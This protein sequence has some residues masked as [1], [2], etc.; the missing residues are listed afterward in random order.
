MIV[1]V[2]GGISGLSA[3][4]H[5]HRAGQNCTLIEKNA[6][7]GG[8]LDTAVW[9]DCV[10]EGGPDSFLAI[11]P[12][13]AQLARELGLEHELISS[14]DAGRVTGVWK[15]GRLV[16]LPEGMMM[17]VPTKVMPMLRSPLLSW[18]TKIRM[19]LEYF[20][21]PGEP[22]ADHSVAAF[23]EDHYGREAVDYLADPL[24][25]GVYGGSAN[26]LSADSVLTRFVELER[27]Y[28]SLTRGVLESR[29][30]SPPG[31]SALF[32]TMKRGLGSLAEAIRASV[33]DHMRVIHG[34]VRALERSG[35]AWRMRVGADWLD[36]SAVIL[37]T[38]AWAAG[39]LLRPLDAELARL[40]ETV[41][42]SSS[43]TISLVYRPG[44]LKPDP[45][46][47]GFLVPRVEKRNLLAC[48]FVHN[49][50]PFR[51]PPGYAILRCFLGGAGNA[52]V[53]E[54]SDDQ[55]MSAVMRDL[56][57]IMGITVQ[58]DHRRIVRWRRAMAQYTV[59]HAHRMRAVEE[60]RKALPGLHLAGNAFSGIGISDC[61][62]T[63]R[64]AAQAAL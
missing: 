51:A 35:N 39:R 36:A 31:E 18:G 57:D 10:L 45:V 48:T 22:Q 63:G 29:K 4:W 2:G 56:H 32:R 20:R 6:N 12:E 27:R 21:R 14:N 55:L 23:I 33:G 37:A 42:Y 50:F 3:A 7:L 5:L 15:H 58:P 47:F 52:G 64:Q 11:K 19:G 28:G 40:L 25:S 54:E 26:A 43:I 53:V 62:R 13:A 60:R 8:V 9:E 41:D 24:L 34:E 44:R 38:P 61:I 17:M 49:K 16:P 46:G 30:K 1:I 59:G